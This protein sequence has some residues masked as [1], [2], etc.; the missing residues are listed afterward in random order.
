VDDIQKL[1]KMIK[2]SK[3]KK[4]DKEEQKKALQ[5][6]TEILRNNIGKE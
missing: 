6:E 3:E 4:L 2:E 5:A 1:E